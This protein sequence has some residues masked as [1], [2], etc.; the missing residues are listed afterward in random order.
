[1]FA[2]RILEGGKRAAPVP[3]IPLGAVVRLPENREG[4]A[5]FVVE[6]KAGKSIPRIWNVELGEA[7]G[8]LI[9]V[10]AGLSPADRVITTC[11]TLVK[12]GW[13]VKVIK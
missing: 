5:V 3:V 6:E 7:Y 12:D 2:S 13:E 9:A 11:A 4:Y 8:N 10:K 1:M